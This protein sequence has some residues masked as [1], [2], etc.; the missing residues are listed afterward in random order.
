MPH[1]QVCMVVIPGWV[2]ALGV[3]PDPGVAIS[4]TS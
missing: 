2:V 1:Q 4:M 3:Y